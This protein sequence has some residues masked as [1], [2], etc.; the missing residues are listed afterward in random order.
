MRSSN[1][2]LVERARA[3]LAELAVL[4][5]S[6]VDLAELG[7]LLKDLH[8]T[9]AVLDAVDAK[10]VEA[11]DSRQAYRA[12]FA[13]TA[14]SW[15]R[16][17]TRVSEADARARVRVARALRSL[18]LAADALAEGEVSW[19][20]V[21]RIAPVVG[22]LQDTP[23][24]LPRLE[25][26]LVDFAR[27]N[28]PDDLTRL[29]QAAAEAAG[30]GESAA[31][32]EQR[33]LA[34]RSFTT[35]K[36]LDGW[37]HV[38]GLLA[39]ELGDLLE[40]V[41]TGLATPVPGIDGAPDDRTA[42]QRRHDALADAI[43]LVV[44]LDTVPEVNGSRPRLTL[45]ADVAT[46]RVDDP[47]WAARSPLASV[48]T[49][50][51][52]PAALE[53]LTCDAVIT[54]LLTT[55]LGVPLAEGRAKRFVTSAQLKALKARDGGCI[56]P[57]CDRVRL[58]A[59]HVIPWSKGG[60]SDISSYV[61]FCKRHHHIAHEDGWTVEPDP[62]RP[63]LFQLRPPDDRPPIRARHTIDRDPGSTTPIW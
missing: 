23:D 3:C 19:Q 49:R 45:V 62:D 38:T 40:Q 32:R 31:E 60:L 29:V 53:L 13:V 58:E 11:F 41:L 47:A 17:H 34:Q 48:L 9:R 55:G 1:R 42:A 56:V 4:D 7:P 46:I 59:H 10:V 2:E 27:D 36:S 63:G 54:P 8:A 15:L 30:V 12:D 25:K 33:R 26:T 22:Y 20:H 61:L 21:R 57:G 52:G 35:T 5:L 16:H 28:T 18:P 6:G 37:R 24:E 44:D 50:S 14:A 43:G 51:L 39:P